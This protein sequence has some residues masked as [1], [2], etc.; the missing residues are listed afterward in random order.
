MKI[1]VAC[2]GSG[3]HLLPGLLAARALQARG[4]AVSLWLAGRETE[5]IVLGEWTGE[6]IRVAALGMPRALSLRMIPFALALVRSWIVC[7]RHMRA[8]TPAVLLAM[9][10]YASAGPVLAARSLGVPVVL[11]EANAV[12]GRAVSFLSRFA[13]VTAVS[14]PGAGRHLPGAA[15]HHTGLPIRPPGPGRFPRGLRGRG[16]GPV[17]VIGGSQGAHALNELCSRALCLLHRQGVPLQVVHLAGPAEEKAVR[18]RYETEC[19]RGVVFG[20]L[21]D[22]ACAYNAAD[23]AVSRAGAGSCAE[24][25]ACVCAA[26]LVPLPGAPRDHQAENARTLVELGGQ[27]STPRKS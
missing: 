9:G 27:S 1:G 4:H 21:E 13:A 16:S 25:A 3:G 5:R 11:H 23:C 18:L 15:T 24:L 2:G 26:L 8:H 7:R 6:T 10:G 12:P 17:L 20:F 22:M 14:F 19:V